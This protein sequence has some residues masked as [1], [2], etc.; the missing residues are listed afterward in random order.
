MQGV[1]VGGERCAEANVRRVNRSPHLRRHGR[2]HLRD[3]ADR[4][5]RAGV[6]E[7]HEMGLSN[8]LVRDGD[9][10]AP[11]EASERG[12]RGRESESEEERTHGHLHGRLDLEVRRGAAHFGL[13]TPFL[14]CHGGGG[15]VKSKWRS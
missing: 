4:V 1:D 14:T 9:R 11:G 6:E 15:R 5:G 10:K 12:C 2:D 8:T 3:R 13:A 7:A